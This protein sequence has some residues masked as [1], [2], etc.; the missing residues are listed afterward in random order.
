M[1]NL[2]SSKSVSVNELVKNQLIKHK[3][4]IQTGFQIFSLDSFDTSQYLYAYMDMMERSVDSNYD[5]NF[6]EFNAISNNALR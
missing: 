6:E 3:A 1:A 5:I 4:S 2:S